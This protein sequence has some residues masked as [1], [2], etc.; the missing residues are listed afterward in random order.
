M[1][2]CEFCEISKNTFFYRTPPVA[3]SDLN[4]IHNGKMSCVVV[5]RKL[6]RKVCHLYADYWRIYFSRMYCSQFV[7]ILLSFHANAI[8]GTLTSILGSVGFHENVRTISI[9]TQTTSPKNTWVNPRI[10][11]LVFCNSFW[12]SSNDFVLLIQ[13]LQ[14]LGTVWKFKIGNTRL[15]QVS[16][17]FIRKALPNFP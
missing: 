12:E 2:S 1:F 16:T 3:A 13:T 14:S 10:S 17:W 11:T 9:S 8:S 6:F 15:N 7:W 5:L 4:V